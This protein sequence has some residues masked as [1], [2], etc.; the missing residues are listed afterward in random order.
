VTWPDEVFGRR[1]AL[2]MRRASLRRILKKWGAP[3]WRI[4]PVVLLYKQFRCQPNQSDREHRDQRDW[5]PKTPPG[6]LPQGLKVIIILVAILIALVVV[7]VLIAS[8]V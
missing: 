3:P 2:K 1:S 8:V 7:V 5:L 4:R 6:P